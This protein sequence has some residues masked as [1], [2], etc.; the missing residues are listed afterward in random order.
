MS[1][2]KK[3]VFH[4]F[5]I[6]GQAGSDRI[7]VTTSEP[8]I[9]ALGGA[10]PDRV[11][12]VLSSYIPTRPAILKGAL[13]KAVEKGYTLPQLASA[14]R[15]GATVEQVLLGQRSLHG[16]GLSSA[17]ER[18]LAEIGRQAKDALRRAE[19]MTRQKTPVTVTFSSLPF[20]KGIQYSLYLIDSTHTNPAG[21][22]SVLESKAR[23]HRQRVKQKLRDEVFGAFKREGYSDQEILRLTHLLTE[24]DKRRFL[25]TLSIVDQNRV[26]EMIRLAQ[27]T[28]DDRVA[29]VAR[30]VN[31]SSSVVLAQA[32][33][34]TLPAAP[35]WTVTISME[36]NSVAWLVLEELK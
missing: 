20:K 29:D 13:G 15:D 18:D 2:I 4:A 17:M 32:A 12:A 21:D 19:E 9:G 6:L 22:K 36:P 1:F 14:F 34:Q 11:T 27:R 25:S 8:L 33:A 7:D 3:P 31:R 26:L 24:P 5:S 10:G 28:E 16:L 30:E 23:A 35:Q